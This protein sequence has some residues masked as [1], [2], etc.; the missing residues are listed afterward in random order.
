MSFGTIHRSFRAPINWQGT[1]RDLRAGRR[2][3]HS[4]LKS[5]GTYDLASIMREAVR[6]ARGAA[7]G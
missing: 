3:R 7:L 6:H 5:D 1:V 2:V 4:Y